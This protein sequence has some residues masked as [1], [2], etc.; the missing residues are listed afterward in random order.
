MTH[1]TLLRPKIDIVVSQPN[2][3]IGLGY[4]AGMLRAHHHKVDILDCAIRKD[5]YPRIISLVK[6]I[7][8]EVVG[9]TALSPYY[10]HMRLLARQL[11]KLKIPIILGGVHVSALPELSLRECGADFVV[12]GEGELTTL[13]L[14]DKW[15]DE[16][17]KKQIQGIA[18]LENGKFTQNPLRPLIQNLDD[19]PFPAWDLIN[20]LKY[21]R[22]P[23]GMIIKRYPVAPIFTTRGCPYNCAYCASTQF[24][25]RK[26]R[27]RSAKNIVD[28][29]EYLVRTFGIREIHIWDDN[30]TLV[31]KHVV[32][33]C[34]EILQRQLDLVF[35]CPNGVRIDTLNK[36]ILTLMRQTG[37]YSLTFAIESGSQSILNRANKKIDLKVIPKVAKLAKELGYIIPSFFIFGLPGETYTTA[38]RSIQFAKSLPL[39]SAVFFKATPLPGSRIFEDWPHKNDLFK[40]KYEW[41][42]FHA[43]QNKIILSDGKRTLNL[44]K[45]AYRE[46][47]FRPRQIYRLL[48]YFLFYPKKEMFYT[49]RRVLG[50]LTS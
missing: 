46:F 36:E 49:I 42:Q 34:Q 14:M 50:Y 27:R 45:D 48:K 47:I 10:S 7:D 19:L 40:T 33:F 16:E 30:F 3:P 35:S 32:E 31:K 21:P 29:I 37:F 38:R 8:P 23:H 2:P 1:L 5:S 24:W 17:S 18:Y 22:R 20:P 9:I 26:F 43:E 44:P 4:I 6:E 11:R 13:E 28:E 39:D 25:R 15:H 12:I 41:F